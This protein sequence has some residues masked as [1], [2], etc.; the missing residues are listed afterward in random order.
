MQLA[1]WGT[2]AQYIARGLILLG[3]VAFDEYQRNGSLSGQLRRRHPAK[4][5]QGVA[6]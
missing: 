1:G 2:Y 3:A 5:S 4:P 6:Q